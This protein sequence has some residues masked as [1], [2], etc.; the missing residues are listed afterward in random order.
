MVFSATFKNISVNEFGSKIIN[1][2]MIQDIPGT[3]DEQYQKHYGNLSVKSLT[4]KK[5][6][7]DFSRSETN[8]SHLYTPDAS[9]MLMYESSEESDSDSD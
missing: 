5:I 8:Q 4:M 9:A 1:S 6:N 2:L 7:F 3:P